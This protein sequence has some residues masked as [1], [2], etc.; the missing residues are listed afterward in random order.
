ML[1]TLNQSTGAATNVTSLLFPVSYTNPI[2]TS[3]DFHPT[4]GILF[5]TVKD[6]PGVDREDGVGD[7]P[8]TPKYLVTINTETGVVTIIGRTETDLDAI[9]FSGGIP[10]GGEVSP[11]NKTGVLAP[12]IMLLA[13]IVLGGAFTIWRRRYTY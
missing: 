6:K 9:A 3:M 4:S 11:V 8:G 7:G 10:V 5:A 12:W 1:Y 2:I 13:V